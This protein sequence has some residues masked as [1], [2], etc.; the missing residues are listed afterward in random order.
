MEGGGGGRL[1]EI[2]AKWGGGGGVYPHRG[3]NPREYGIVI[4]KIVPSVLMQTVL[5]LRHKLN[6]KLIAL[7]SLSLCTNIKAFRNIHNLEDC[8]HCLEE[9][10][11][12]RNRYKTVKAI[13]RSVLGI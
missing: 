10:T 12:L 2:L 7:G 4:W 8:L 11:M 13:H 6:L 9:L 5:E 3:I 1:C